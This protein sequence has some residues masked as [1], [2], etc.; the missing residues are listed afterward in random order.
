MEFLEKI[1]EESLNEI[2]V[3]DSINYKF[4]NL[5]KSALKN[6]GYSMQ[7]LKNMTPLDI[8]PKLTPD[9]FET[10]IRNTKENPNKKYHFRTINKRKNG[11]EYPVLVSLNYL[12]LG[13]PIFVAFIFDESAVVKEIDKFI[14]IFN[15]HKAI[16]LLIDPET[17]NILDAN[18]SA[19]TYYGY[20]VDELKNMKIQQINILNDSEIKA[21]MQ[22]AKLEKRNYFNF[23]H[24][25][26]NG[27]I[28]DVEVYSCPVTIDGRVVLYSIIFDITKLNKL[29][30]SLSEEVKKMNLFLDGLP[31]PVW[32]INRDKKIILQNSKAVDKYNTKVGEYCWYGIHK[33]KHLEEKYREAF[34]KDGTVLPGAQCW[35][36]KTNE[37]F[38]QKTAI[39]EIVEI[40]N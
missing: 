8:K 30:A 18:K 13:K 31:Y 11:T 29:E 32:I 20:S 7:E 34:E 2:Y 17:G 26:K 12:N 33:G 16:K 25:L 5:N 19:A 9:D 38:E 36:C 40:G 23:K 4:L 39:N 28:K 37:A 3:F 35:Y 21:E 14:T 1:I 24:K 15:E 27:V 22:K 6:I 10:I